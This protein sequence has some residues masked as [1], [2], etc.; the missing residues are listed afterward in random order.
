MDTTLG[1]E[2]LGS[3]EDTDPQMTIRIECNG[4][5]LRVLQSEVKLEQLRLGVGQQND[6]PLQ[7]L[8][9]LLGV[10]TLLIRRVSFNSYAHL[11]VIAIL[12]IKKGVFGKDGTDY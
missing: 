11:G 8:K 5:T 9:C 3:A 7:L 12:L 6:S 1:R 2:P 10:S 4:C